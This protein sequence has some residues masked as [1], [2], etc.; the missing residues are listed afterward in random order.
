MKYFC[1]FIILISFY[2]SNAQSDPLFQLEESKFIGDFIEK[3]HEFNIDLENLKQK[4]E[5]SPNRS[6]DRDQWKIISL[7]LANGVTTQIKIAESSILSPEMQIEY[8]TIKSYIVA[9]HNNNNVFGRLSITP[10]G[11]TGLL[12]TDDGDVYYEVLK[13]GNNIAYISNGKD[14]VQSSCGTIHSANKTE[15]YTN[16]DSYGGETRTFRMAV[17]CSGEFSNKYN[18]NL[19]TIN[20]KIN[21]YLTELNAIYERDIAITFQLAPNNNDIIF[22]NP[23]TDGLDD[24][25][26]LPTAFEVISSNMNAADYEIGH[27]FHELNDPGNGFF[28]GSGVAGLGNVCA[29]G[30]N[31]FNNKSSGWSACGG[32]YTTSFWMGIFAHEVGHQFNASH[33]FYGTSNFCGASGQRSPGNG[34]EPGSG[35]SMMSYEGTCQ[36]N[37]SC[38]NQNITPTSNFLYFHGHSINQIQNYIAGA[39]NCSNDTPNSNSAPVITM[40]Q[41]YTIPIGTPFSLSANATDADGDALL[42]GWEEIDTDNLTLSCPDGAPN[43]AANSTT[44][45]LFRS[46]DPSSDGGMRTFPKLSDILNNTQTLG[47]ILPNVGRD[48]DFRF[49]AR[50]EA[51]GGVSYE[52]M[53][54]NVAGSAGPFEV[55]TANSAAGYQGGQSLNMQWSVANTNVA[56]VSC[57]NVNILF[58]T[59]GGETFPITLASNTPNDGSHTITLPSTATNTGRIKIE[60]VNNIFFDINNADIVISSDCNPVASSILNDEDV[61]ADA[62]DPALDLEILTGGLITNFAGTLTTSDPSSTLIARN[63]ATNECA[64]FSVSQRYKSIVVEVL[65]TDTYTFTPNSAFTDVLN[66]YS[67][68][69]NP[70]F[71]QQCN[72]WLA[73]TASWNP[74][75]T[76]ISFANSTS[77]S[78]QAGDIIEIVLSGYFSNSVGDFDVVF[79]SDNGGQLAQVTDP[80]NGYSYTFI[81]SDENGNIVSI[82]PDTDL[83]DDATFAG[84]SYTIEGLMLFGTPDLSSYIN[85]PLSTLKNAI[86]AGNPCGLFSTNDKTVI[87][88]GCTPSTKIVTSFLDNGGPGTL[89]SVIANSCPGDVIT[90]L[91]DLLGVTISLDSEILINIELTITGLGIN[92]TIISG[93]SSNRIFN[94][95]AGNTLTL[96]DLDLEDGFSSTDGGAILNSGTLN[97]QDVRFENNKS[98]SND[99][100]LTNDG[101]INIRS[102]NVQINK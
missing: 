101:I 23:A 42:L 95:S 44:A 76:N 73:S 81:I 52:D 88:N 47:E 13:N 63:E 64:L 75:T 5:N 9:S 30:S 15:N 35:N 80:P 67:D 72:T 102:G 98:G 55:L 25:N 78:L 7:P 45:P 89:R 74:V 34:V 90:F 37:G 22:F 49:T 3:K 43:D 69:F 8:P 85:Q 86:A 28:N 1:V 41:D 70:A 51:L 96:I 61:T 62:G 12:F 56:P 79:S 39:G 26:R 94:N 20:S 68:Q 66:I 24:N 65:D 91:T 100:A 84:G 92:N 50:A 59:N 21:E 17:A 77:V 46:F 53:T 11:L 97:L 99:K 19:T 16:R 29:D 14:K 58:S 87:I 31:W 54:V 82:D 48:I 57:T 33:T 18:N 60:A 27:V 32:P 40:P 93:G 71:G 83:S 6:A 38:S 4:L 36:A 2:F 10:L